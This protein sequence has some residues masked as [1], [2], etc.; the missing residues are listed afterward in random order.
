MTQKR[1][2]LPKFVV[3]EYFSQI[4][5][6]QLSDHVKARLA[7]AVPSLPQLDKALQVVSVIADLEAI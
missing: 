7:P 3:E 4:C 1:A 6:A 2:L 5:R